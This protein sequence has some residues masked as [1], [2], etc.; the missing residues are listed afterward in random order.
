[1]RGET[2]GVSSG[3]LIRHATE[4]THEGDTDE[5]SVAPVIS[6]WVAACF[7]QACPSSERDLRDNKNK[8][9]P[10]QRAQTLILSESLLRRR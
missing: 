7:P 4:S 5:S 2:G 9:Y 6:E 8:T 10:R 3:N 1:M